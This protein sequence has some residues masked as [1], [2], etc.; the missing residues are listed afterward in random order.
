MEVLGELDLAFEDHH[1]RSGVGL[2]G[3]EDDGQMAGGD[4]VAG[5]QD[6]LGLQGNIVDEGAVLAAEI[7]DGPV[8]AVGFESEVLARQAGIFGE[9]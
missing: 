8:F 6:Q 5:L 4:A 1:A 9:A 7:L 2:I 3:S